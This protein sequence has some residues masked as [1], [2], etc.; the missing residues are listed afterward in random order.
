MGNSIGCCPV[1]PYLYNRY[2]FRRKSFYVS[3]W[4]LIDNWKL[5]QE[6]YF[7]V[8]ITLYLQRLR[9]CWFLSRIVDIIYVVFDLQIFRIFGSS[10]LTRVSAKCRKLHEF[11]DSAR[12]VIK[13]EFKMRRCSITLDG[14]KF[15]S[16]EGYTPPCIH[17][18]Y[19]Y[20]LVQPRR[21]G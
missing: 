16:L 19:A 8:Q 5:V 21:E 14:K 15:L 6:R 2:C 12:Y 20:E 3:I 7:S 13:A 1:M 4:R 9:S 17:I 18:A 11:H 10:K